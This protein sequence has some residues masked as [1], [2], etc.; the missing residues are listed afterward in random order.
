MAGARNDWQPVHGNHPGRQ[1][2]RPE[3][4]VL[5]SYRCC[6]TTDHAHR[7]CHSFGRPGLQP[8]A[9]RAAGSRG[10]RLV[11]GGRPGGH[12]H[13]REHRG[14]FLGRSDDHGQ[15]LYRHDPG[16]KRCR[17][18]SED[19]ATDGGGDT[20]HRRDTRSVRSDW[21]TVCGSCA[22]ASG[23]YSADHVV[24]GERSCW[25]DDQPDNGRCVVGEP[26]LEDDPVFSDHPCD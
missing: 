9:A 3:R 20:G 23:G 1:F 26:S 12:G 5:A 14:G 8:N 15:S 10:L 13:R 22:H 6:P 4:C 7:R 2:R 18:R 16:R 17:R 19:M 25:D 21:P 24:V 11:F